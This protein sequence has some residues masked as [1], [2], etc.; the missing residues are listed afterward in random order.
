MSEIPTGP[1]VRR[2]KVP[3]P[4]MRGNNQ[5]IFRRTFGETALPKPFPQMLHGSPAHRLASRDARASIGS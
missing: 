5:H 1:M 3:L 4:A 2:T